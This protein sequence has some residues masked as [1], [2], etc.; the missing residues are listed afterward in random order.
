MLEAVRTLR[1]DCPV[2]CLMMA[3]EISRSAETHETLRL[4]A[5]VGTVV[6]AL[7][8]SGNNKQPKDTRRP[9]PNEP[10]MSLAPKIPVANCAYMAFRVTDRRFL[11]GTA[12]L[13]AR[14]RSCARCRY[15][16]W[17]AFCCITMVCGRRSGDI[18]IW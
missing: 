3:L 10:Q 5:L 15:I 1:S 6:R 17:R 4:W 2:F 16:Y 12:E 13:S 18:E 9:E 8:F 14:I 11:A 7:V